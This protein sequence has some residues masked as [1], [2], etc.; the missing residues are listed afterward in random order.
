MAGVSRQRE[1]TTSEKADLMG[2]YS[3]GLWDYALS[4]YDQSIDVAMHDG[5]LGLKDVMSAC[6]SLQEEAGYDVCE[7]LWIHW[8]AANGVMLATSPTRLLESVRD[9]QSWMTGM[10]RERRQQLKQELMSHEPMSDD[11]ASR[12]LERLYEQLKACELSAEQE[13]LA[14]LEAL[15]PANDIAH[16][17]TP[18]A[19]SQDPLLAF[20]QSVALLKGHAGWGEDDSRVTRTLNL[21]ALTRVPAVKADAELVRGC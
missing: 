8:L 7:L 2:A 12:R 4:L 13:T 18:F 10:L 20:Q 3:T 21:L 19:R 17:N 16:L 14:Q 5:S 1:S 6:L 15:S 9:W 11:S